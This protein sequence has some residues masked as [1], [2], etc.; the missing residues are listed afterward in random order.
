MRLLKNFIPWLISAALC[1][2]AVELLGAGVA[3]WTTKSI[4]YL[5][6]PK[7]VVTAPVAEE[8]FKR[9]LHPYFGYTG[10]YSRRGFVETNSLGFLQRQTLK[11][12]FVPKPNDF[13]VFVF[14]GSVAARLANNA[15]EGIPLQQTLQDLPQLAGKN[16]ILY[17]VAQ[18]PGKQPQQLMVL[19]YLIAV[20]QHIDLVLNMDGTLEFVNG[21]MNFNFGVDPIFPPIAVLQ[22][23][24]NELTPMETASQDY[25]ELAYGVTHARAEFKRYSTLLDEST[26]GIAYLKN[27]LLRGYYDR[28]LAKQLTAYSETVAKGK[29][30][31]G[32][33]KRLGLDMPVTTTRE[34]MIED[35]FDVWLRSSDLMKSMANSVGAKHLHIVHP[36]MY[37]SKKKYTEAEKALMTLPEVSEPSVAGQSLMQSRAEMLEQ[38]GIVSALGLFDD[39]PET[40]YVDTTGHFGKQGET[41]FAEFVARHVGLRLGAPPGK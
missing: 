5:N 41:M 28:S 36:N 21:V 13:V 32:V 39:V 19:A 2:L 26:T 16:V 8:N 24:G 7:P 22:A 4:V 1:V 37:H 10:D 9:H 29:G 18:G 27:R 35:I 17:N 40:I 12:P 25:Y 31:E 38:R 6:A 14:G 20:G 11:V 33:R 30:W 15:M 34:K 3:W 23:I